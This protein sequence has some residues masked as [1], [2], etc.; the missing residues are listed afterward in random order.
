MPSTFHPIVP[1][2]THHRCDLLAASNTRRSTDSTGNC[3]WIP[4]RQRWSLAPMVIQLFRKLSRVCS[5][6]QPFHISMT[7]GWLPSLSTHSRCSGSWISWPWE[8]VQQMQ[9]QPAGRDARSGAVGPEPTTTRSWVPWCPL[10][11]VRL[12]LCGA[13]SS[14]DS[15]VEVCEFVE[16]RA[17]APHLIALAVGQWSQD[18]RGLESFDG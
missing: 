13:G 18:P 4:F 10:T 1:A 16:Q 17:R 14:L 7:L 2:I 3:I 5:M 15:R 11:P 6:M 12:C 9:Q 8:S